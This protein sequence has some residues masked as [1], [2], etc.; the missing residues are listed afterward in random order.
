MRVHQQI[1]QWCRLHGTTIY[2]LA[3][4]ARLSFATLHK[5]VFGRNNLSVSSLCAVVAASERIASGHGLTAGQAVG[6]EP[7]V[8]G[9]RP[10]HHASKGTAA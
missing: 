6:L 4:E 7:L 8:R 10:K 2:A 5:A 9:Q 3:K 1:P